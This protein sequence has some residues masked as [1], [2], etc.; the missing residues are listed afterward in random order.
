MTK[1]ILHPLNSA[2]KVSC[3]SAVAAV[4]VLVN[5]ANQNEVKS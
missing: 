3:R 2:T 4:P 5:L 1:L